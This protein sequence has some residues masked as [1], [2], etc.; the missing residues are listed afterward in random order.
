MSKWE[1]SSFNV[2]NSVQNTSV[3][4]RIYQICCVCS[5]TERCHR[6]TDIR[7]QYTLFSFLSLHCIVQYGYIKLITC[8]LVDE[9]I[10]VLSAYVDV[11]SSMCD[12]RVCIYFWFWFSCFFLVHSLR[13]D[14][15]HTH[16]RRHTNAHI[17][18]MRLT[19]ICK[20]G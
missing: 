18:R 17:L 1:N 7:I 11:I 13:C 6:L 15:F 12:V 19:L 3:L 20:L 14:A 4:R 8:W 10:G 2:A 9:L 16:A 5:T